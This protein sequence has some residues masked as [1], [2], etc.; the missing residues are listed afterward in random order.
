M[1]FYLSLKLN[2]RSEIVY[3]E[4]SNDLFKNVNILFI[5]V[6]IGRI[7]LNIFSSIKI[8]TSKGDN[9]N[10]LYCLNMRFKIC[11]AVILRTLG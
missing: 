10:Y 1:Q 11:S 9:I 2:Y 4:S 8:F 6:I 7:Q 5:K 3:L